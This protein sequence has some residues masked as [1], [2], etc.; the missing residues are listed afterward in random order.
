MNMTTIKKVVAPKS[1]KAEFGQK[2]TY[3][4]LT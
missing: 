2:Q 1:R 3:V 4:A